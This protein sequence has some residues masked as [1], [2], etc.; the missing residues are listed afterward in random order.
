MAFWLNLKVFIKKIHGATTVF[1][2]SPHIA[3]MHTSW[4]ASR[5]Y[6]KM[7]VDGTKKNHSLVVDDTIKKFT[8]RAKYLVVKRHT[9]PRITSV[10][11]KR[12]VFSKLK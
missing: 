3:R 1:V 11:S 8:T 9:F 10:T 5:K 4:V 7:F 6:C 12:F 2:F